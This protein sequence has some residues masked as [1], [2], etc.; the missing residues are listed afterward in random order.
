VP[1]NEISPGSYYVR[2]YTR[3]PDGTEQRIRGTYFFTVQ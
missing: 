3:N 1:A 2:L